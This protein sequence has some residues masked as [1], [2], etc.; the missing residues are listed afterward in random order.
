[1]E[2]PIPG[3]WCHLCPEAPLSL[4]SW[5]QISVQ[6]H[7]LITHGIILVEVLRPAMSYFLPNSPAGSKMIKWWSFFVSFYTQ[8]EIY[9]NKSPAQGL[10]NQKQTKKFASSQFEKEYKDFPYC[11]QIWLSFYK[12]IIECHNLM[13]LHFLGMKQDVCTT[14]IWNYIQKDLKFLVY[15]RK[16][17]NKYIRDSEILGNI[18]NISKVTHHL[19]PFHIGKAI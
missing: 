9:K 5:V 10:G 4:H 17:L 15:I 8:A 18:L 19:S 1:M 11:N 16:H 3:R 2:H 12:E 7:Y 6:W 13:L 14:K